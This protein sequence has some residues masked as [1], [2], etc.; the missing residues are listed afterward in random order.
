M[1]VS[2]IVLDQEEIKEE[3]S[4]DLIKVNII[5]EKLETKIALSH[6]ILTYTSII[7]GI[8]IITL[9][10]S[11]LLGFI[12]H[13]AIMLDAIMIIWQIILIARIAII[14]REL[15]LIRNDFSESEER[16]NNNK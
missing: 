14:R 4:E 15:E 12:N 1:S 8:T 7:T 13:T 11:A 5:E 3:C 16:K 10:Y 9:L 6:S 2:E